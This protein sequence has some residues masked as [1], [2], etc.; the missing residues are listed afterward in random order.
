MEI[1]MKFS[2]NIEKLEKLI[3]EKERIENILVC[4]GNNYHVVSGSVIYSYEDYIFYFDGYSFN[5]E[6]DEI[7]SYIVLP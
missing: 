4:T 5:L 2:D 3:I 6:I 1:I 7:K